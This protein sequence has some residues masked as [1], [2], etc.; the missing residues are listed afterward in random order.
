MHIHFDSVILLLGINATDAYI[1]EYGVYFKLHKMQIVK[2]N[3]VWKYNHLCEKGP[4]HGRLLIITDNI[5]IEK[6]LGG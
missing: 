2:Y 1:C 4:M 5:R 3:V 6:K